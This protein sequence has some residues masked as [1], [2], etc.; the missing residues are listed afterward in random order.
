MRKLICLLVVLCLCLSLAGCSGS[1]GGGDKQPAGNNTA[2]PQA[3]ADPMAETLVIGAKADFTNEG[4][5]MV[6]D[7]LM[8]RVNSYEATAYVVSSEHNADYTEFTLTLTPG[9]KFSDGAALT[10]EDIKYSIETELPISN[11][12]FGS[13]LDSIEVKDDSTLIVHLNAPFLNMDYELSYIY[14]VRPG[15]ISDD[16]NYIAWIGTG[17][18]ILADHQQDVSATFTRNENYWNKAKMG[19]PRTVIWK[20]L[21]DETTRV[22][23]LEKKE[24]DVIGPDSHAAAGIAA[25]TLSEI[26]KKGVLKIMDRVGGS[27]QTYMYNY[28]N[29]PMSDLELRKAVTYAVDR[30]AMLD[31]A[32]FGFGYV[33]G[34]FLGDDAKYAARN[35]EGYTYDPEK[36]KQILADA[37]YKDTDGDGFV[38]KDGQ[39]VVLQFVTFSGD[40]YR[41]IAVLFQESLKAVGIDCEINALENTLFYERTNSGD[42]DI[43]M[44]HPWT[45]AMAYMTW[46]GGYSDYDN[47]GPG[48]GVNDNFPGYLEK[49]L[50]STDE[51]EIY[52]TFDKIWAEIYAA[53]PATPL[54]AGMSVYVYTDEV[55]GF[56]WTRGTQNLIDFSEVVINRK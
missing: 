36:A 41:T 3:A 22:M 9:I 49:I 47:F 38:E 29:G 54:Y 32:A 18:Y 1:S 23:A 53:Y 51:E 11:L 5:N 4:K 17:P 40:T 12:G 56:I 16:G 42:F 14:A 20:V 35:G 27:P 37:G 30:Q 7:M 21:P 50:T 39:K 46:R 28:T 13:V 6:F 19:K 2:A 34:T 33:M 8:Y 24:V 31:T 43:C 52:A 45:T 15:T 10:A 44:C 55:S 25:S 26:K 48:F